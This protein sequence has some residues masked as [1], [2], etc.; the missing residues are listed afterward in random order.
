M[1]LQGSVSSL[2]LCSAWEKWETILLN[3]GRA[4]FNG[5]WTTSV[6]ANWIELMEW[7]IFPGFISVGNFNQIQQMMGEN[8]CDPENFKGNI[9]FISLFNDI[10][11][12]TKGKDELCENSSKTI[13]KVCWQI[14]SWLLVFLGEWIWKVSGTELQKWW[15]S[16]QIQN[17]VTQ[18]FVHPMLLK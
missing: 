16:N 1:P 8:Q 10:V 7:K 6:S 9:I 12:D 2:T 18:Y 5:I 15:Y 14:P 4:K 11:W 3:L 17:P 13:K